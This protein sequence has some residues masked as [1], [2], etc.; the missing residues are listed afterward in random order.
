MR[1]PLSFVYRWCTDYTPGDGKCGGEDNTIHLKRRIIEDKHGRVVFENLFDVGRGWGWERHIV[2]LLPPNRW[3]SA[4]R[5]N[6]QESV[7]DYRLRPLSGDRTRFTIR[8]K[9]RPMGRSEGSRPSAAS[10]EGYVEKLWKRRARALERAYGLSRTR[11]A[12]GRQR[13]AKRPPI[14]RSR[15]G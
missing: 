1:A 15:P 4:G 12:M 7:L 9:S 6:Y 5:G 10:I 14:G 3:H 13:A 11:L 8:W 2:T